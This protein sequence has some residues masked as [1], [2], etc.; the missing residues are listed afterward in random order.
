MSFELLQERLSAL[1]ETTTQIKELI[2]RLSTLK[3]Q[4]G[5]I[6]LNGT[7][8][9][10]SAELTGEIHQLLREQDEDF[11]LLVEEVRDLEGGRH[12]SSQERD[13]EELLGMTL[14]AMTELKPMQAS[15]RSAQ[16][17]AKANRDAAQ[18]AERALLQSFANQGSTADGEG[19]AAMPF[20]GRRQKEKAAPLTK[21][22]KELHASSDVT[23]ALRRT[24]NLM[25]SELSRSQFAHD[26]LKESTA[27]LS[28]LSETYSTLDTLLAGSR[29]LLG[30][31][32]KSQKS[33]T[34]YLT[35]TF[36]ILVALI[37]W[38]V[39]R[40]FLYGPAWW[41]VYMPLKWFLA[42]PMLIFYKAWMGVF[43]AVGLRSSRD[44]VFASSAEGLVQTGSGRVSATISGSAAPSMT[45]SA[46]NSQQ[47]NSEGSG[48]G[49]IEEV[50]RIVDGTPEGSEEAGNLNEDGSQKN[51]KKRMWEE[52]E[53]AKKE[54]KQK[55]KDE[56]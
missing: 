37:G 10:V 14:R 46:S 19:A 22:E 4:P 9:D 1:Q 3:F 27:A 7:E 33:D 56:L 50:G 5:S 48:D 20:A 38:L 29:N 21:A 32:L 35:T 16:L 24:H 41:L 40:R 26:T 53:E 34:W 6:P 17:C 47:D 42:K 39:F 8:G 31:L 12:G 15:F 18:R 54:E 52:P 36:Y 45:I 25:A 13:K 49:M 30:T 2:S 23:L 55:Q 28:E 43:T 51:P 11:E 44:G